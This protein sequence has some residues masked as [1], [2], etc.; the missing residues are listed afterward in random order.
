MDTI[1]NSGTPQEQADTNPPTP[2]GGNSSQEVRITKAD[3][4]KVQAALGRISDLQSG[5]DI[6]K[7]TQKEVQGL[8]TEVLPLLERAHALGSQNKPLN[9]ALTQIQGEQ[10]EAEFRKAVMELAQTMRGGTQ[11]GG[12]GNASGVDMATVLAEY[13]LDPK[14]PYVASKLAGQTFQSK[15]QAELFAAR[16]LRDKINAPQTNSAQQSAQPGTIN[17]SA[18]GAD[19]QYLRLEQL[20]KNYTANR[21]EIEAIEG[22]LKASGA[23]RR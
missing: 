21:V 23:M 8:R 7:Q 17:P 4:D 12:A 6:A 19:A 10:S 1:T 9:E 14:D 5:R 15:E 16:T 22:T 20:Y 2:D 18:E 3:W 11:P 13:Q